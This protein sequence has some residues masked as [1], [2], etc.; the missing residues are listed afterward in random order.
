MKIAV[1][2]AGSVGCYVGGLLTAGG[3]VRKSLNKNNGFPADKSVEAVDMKARAMDFLQ[4]F[5][6]D[7]AAA[8]AMQDLRR[9][10]ASSYSQEQWLVLE[11]LIDL[12]WSDDMIPLR[13]FHCTA[14]W[15]V[16]PKMQRAKQ[17][18]TPCFH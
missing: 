8:R 18:L 6:E 5:R 2:G 15:L 12:S 7:P 11:A 9:L 10:P 1:L 17:G 4:G 14:A 3:E 16:P 13:P